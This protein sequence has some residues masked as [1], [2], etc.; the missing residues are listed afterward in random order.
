MANTYYHRVFNPLPGQRVDEQVL[1]D[2]FQRIELGFD[3]VATK[4][5]QT[6]AGLAT[7]ANLAGGNAFT[8]DQSM[9]G[10]LTV[11]GAVTANTPLPPGDNSQALAST[12]WVQAWVSARA[13]ETI[14]LPVAPV[15][16]RPLALFV[17][18]GVHQWAPVQSRSKVFYLSGA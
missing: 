9:A 15:Q 1:K 6:D 7:K 13:G 16:A 8:G 4:A 5:G 17:V 12:N 2:E 11:A 3:G 18:Q 14:G 10:N